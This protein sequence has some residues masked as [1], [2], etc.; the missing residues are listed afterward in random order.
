MVFDVCF[1]TESEE[2]LA[3][4]RVF[5]QRTIV[6][7]VK[8]HL[9]EAAN[10]ESERRKQLQPNPLAPWELRIGDYRVFYEIENE[11]VVWIIAIG[12]KVHND[13]FIRGQRVQL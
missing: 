7:A 5:E 2:D 12:W 6:Q 11:Q 1:T 4:F 10:V 3:H 9:R 13:L 8:V